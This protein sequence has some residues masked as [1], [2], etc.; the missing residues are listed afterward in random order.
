MSGKRESRMSSIY[1]I[2]KANELEEIYENEPEPVF[3]WRGIEDVSFGYVFGPSKSGK[4]IFCENLAMSLAVGRDS[5]FNSK[6][7]GKPKKVFFAA[8]EEDYRNRTRRMKKQKNGLTE[9]ELD[10]YNKNMNLSGPNYPRFLN[11]QEDWVQFEKAVQNIAPEVLIIDS[12]TRI[13]NT[14]ITNRDECKKVL[15]RLRNFAYDN[16]MC[17]IVIHHSTKVSGKPLTM[18]GMA[19]SS[20]LSQEGDFSI[21]LNRNEM[22]NMRYLKE[23][24][25]RYLDNN[26]M[27]TC[28][29]VCNETNW[30]LPGSLTYESKIISDMGG[31]SDNYY[32]KI[33]KYLKEK[34]EKLTL[35]D[36][37]LTDYNIKVSELKKEFV[38]TST[39]PGRSFDYTLSNIVKNKVLIPSGAKGNYVYKI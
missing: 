28:Y 38:A 36:N 34:A 37:T 27:V 32:D 22:T 15:A 11:T 17:L 21:G 29:N 31:D 6:M 16:R 13:V 4:T 2:K 1:D 20:V 35:N 24:F 23:V 39:I 14:D 26:D 9:K 5:F 12:L 8:F 18:D 33:E 7:I 10:L 30:L 19:G 25:Y 3:Y